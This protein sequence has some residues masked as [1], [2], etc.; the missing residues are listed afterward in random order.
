M[1]MQNTKIKT[2][3]KQKNWVKLSLLLA[4]K[5]VTQVCYEQWWFFP[6]TIFV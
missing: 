4:D 3:Q 6:N 1:F 2:N 5:E